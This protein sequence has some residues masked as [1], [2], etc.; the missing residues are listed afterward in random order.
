MNAPLRIRQIR[1]HALSVPMRL[2]FEHAAAAR[3]HADPVVVSVSPGAPYAHQVGHGE[4]LGGLFAKRLAEMEAR[5][6]PE[7]L[8][9]IEALPITDEGRVV[10]AARAAVEL[11]LIDLACRIFRRRAADVVHWMDLPGFGEPG[12]L[13]TARYSGIVVGGSESRLKW[14][15]RAQR[16]YG[17]RDFKI[18][19]AVDGWQD[20]LRR[21]HRVLGPAL[22][23]GR[24]TLRADANGGWN[25][26]QACDALPLLR[27]CGVCGLE[28][29]LPESEDALLPALVEKDCCDLIADESLLTLEDARRLIE[30]EAVK[31]FNVR[32]AKNGG[33]MPSL[34]IARAAQ[35]AGRDVQLGCL[36][37]ETSILSAAGVVFLEACPKVRFVEGAFGGFLMKDDV[38]RRRVRFGRGGRIKPRPGFGLDVAVDEAALTRLAAKPAVSVS[39]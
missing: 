14:M 5:S 7:A 4:D 13:R 20:K 10:T 19:V 26:E 2:R 16:W 36:V 25:Y 9:F 27:E 12:S 30:G 15:L 1:I 11:A 37:G 34:R 18:K 31:V 29:P 35:L 8:E 33:L 17:L 6:F 3:D 24:V 23:R 28:Q 39:F 22:K 32:I 21:A 38:T